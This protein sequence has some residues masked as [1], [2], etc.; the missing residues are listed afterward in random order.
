ML[1]RRWRDVRRS[2]RR[3]SRATSA[4]SRLRTG[5][6][7]CLPPIR[8]ASVLP[9]ELSTS[10]DLLGDYLLV[11]KN[12]VVAGTLHE[13]Y[14]ISAIGTVRVTLAT[15]RNGLAIFGIVNPIPVTAVVLLLPI[16]RICDLSHGYAL[17]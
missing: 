3:P 4:G 11:I 17:R 6:G 5:R 12:R 2:E 15:A 14:R 7:E 9:P 10:F 1:E 16:T 8:R 13:I